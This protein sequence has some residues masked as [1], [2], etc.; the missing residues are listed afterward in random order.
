[1]QYCS[2]PEVINSP[3]SW[4]RFETAPTGVQLVV[5]THELAQLS[6]NVLAFSSVPM[7]KSPW[8]ADQ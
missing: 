2:Q 3:T 6:L 1:M 8:D 5:T 4:P 7:S